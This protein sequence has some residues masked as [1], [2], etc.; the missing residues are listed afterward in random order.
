MKNIDVI[1]KIVD[2]QGTY[3]D[4]GNELTAPTYV[5][6]WHVNTTS[7]VAEW[8]AYLCDP[9]PTTPVRIYAGGVTPVCYSFLDEDTFN[10]LQEPTP[11]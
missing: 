9:Q 3:D 10:D 8:S 2:T 1:G 6:G 5:E 7:E 11:P 4:E